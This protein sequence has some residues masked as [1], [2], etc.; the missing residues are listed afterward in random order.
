MYV[1]NATGMLVSDCIYN[2]TT[3]I[4]FI[5]IFFIIINIDNDLLNHWI[6]GDWG[7]LVYK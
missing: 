4:T 7:G 3:Q 1:L 2:N 5:S 6:M